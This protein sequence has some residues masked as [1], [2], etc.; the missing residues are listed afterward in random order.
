MPQYIAVPEEKALPASA[1][2]SRIVTRF[3]PS[4]NGY[5]HIG[6]AFAAIAVHDFAR[7]HEGRFLLR[8]E[9]IDGTRSRGEHIDAIIADLQW[10]GLCWDEVPL[11]QSSQVEAYQAALDRLR[12]QD[13]VY[14]CFCTRQDITA[15][16]RQRAVPHGPD[17]PQYPGS[18]RHIAPSV[19]DERAAKLPFAWRLDMAK[20]I[21]MTGLLVWQERDAGAIIADPGQF[22]DVVLWRKDAPASYHLAATLDDAY[23]AI[24]HVVR[25]FDLYA[26]TAIHRLLQ[27][28]LDLPV[29]QYWHHP[30]LVDPDGSKLAKSKRS[31]SL[32]ERRLAGEDGIALAQSLR[33]GKL[34]L[35]I[36]L[37]PA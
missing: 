7:K 31:P 22:G 2:A 32:L 27:A 6:H 19:S 13:L 8:I 37:A 26:Y 24:T 34:P 4:P 12:S 1:V 9:D 5:L 33:A 29:P 30:L 28:L 17:G 18:C 20:A 23:Q 21:E 25:G 3:A 36:S 16:L 15:T 11:R 10:L 14:R 35:G